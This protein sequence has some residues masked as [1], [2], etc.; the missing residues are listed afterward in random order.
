MIYWHVDRKALCVHSQFKSCSTSEVAAM[1]EGLLRHQS[2]LEVDANYVDSHGQPEIRFA[3]TELLGYRLWGR[4][5][6]DDESSRDSSFHSC[7]LSSAPPWHRRRS[8]AQCGWVIDSDSLLGSCRS[9]R[10]LPPGG[11]PTAA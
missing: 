2:S 1:I 9:G 3:F 7:S 11:T 5:S 6:T 10:G 8:Q 4:F